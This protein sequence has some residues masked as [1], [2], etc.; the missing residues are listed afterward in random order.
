MFLADVLHWN[1]GI[2]SLLFCLLSRSLARKSVDSCGDTAT[3]EKA[4]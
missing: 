3:F 2:L 4:E 1:H